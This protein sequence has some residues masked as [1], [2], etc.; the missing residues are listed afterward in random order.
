MSLERFHGLQNHL[1]VTFH[2]A[3]RQNGYI[4]QSIFAE[5]WDVIC[6]HIPAGD[7]LCLT[8]LLPGELVLALPR[9]EDSVQELAGPTELEWIPC[10][11]Q[12]S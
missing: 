2:R 12:T 1:G 7:P 3:D 11:L 8:I 5:T 9:G 4:F 6:T 10:T